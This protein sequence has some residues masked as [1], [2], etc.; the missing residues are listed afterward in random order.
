[1]GADRSQDQEAFDAADRA[2]KYDPSKSAYYVQRG[3]AR[4]SLGHGR[5]DLEVFQREDIDPAFQRGEPSAA[6]FGL[7]AHA[8]LAA[9]REKTGVAAVALI[10]D[11]TKD[12]DKAIKESSGGP[13]YT[14]LLDGGAAAY[15][16]LANLDTGSSIEQR[17]DCLKDAVRLAKLS[18]NVEYRPYPEYAWINLGNAEEDF[19]F[20]VGDKGDH[21]CNAIDAFGKAGETA[22]KAG[23]SPAF[24]HFS[25]GRCRCKLVEDLGA[26]L[27][28][29]EQAC[30]RSI[31]DHLQ[32][33][34]DELRK[35]IEVGMDDP[36]G[37]LTN[38]YQAEAN[39]WR[40]KLY[41]LKAAR[42]ADDKESLALANEAILAA[43]EGV[44]ETSENW[45]AYQDWSAK[46]A[47]KMG[48][49]ELAR[50]RAEKLLNV[51]S[52][53]LDK[54][55]R[56]VRYLVDSYT[57]QGDLKAGLEAY[58]KYLDAPEFRAAG[59]SRVDLL[60]LCSFHISRNAAALWKDN[61][62]LCEQR[63]R[64]A[65]KL[66]E[67]IPDPVGA[68][69]A[70][71]ALAEHMIQANLSDGKIADFK[72][73]AECLAKA[74]ALQPSLPASRDARIAL[75]EA[76]L[77]LAGLSKLPAAER[78]RYATKGFEALS[79]VAEAASN[80]AQRLRVAELRK[81]LEALSKASK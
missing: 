21:Y 15:V 74:I 71:L 2:V 58:K 25:Q 11:A 42:P 70:Y 34:L 12:Y 44:K 60:T 72:E 65:I 54:K 49:P 46:I 23:R 53:P 64:Q 77:Q 50:Q 41:F 52:A 6:A 39:Y 45:P 19:T 14:E 63:A 80:S 48:Q 13:Y 32:T 18:T 69:K 62:Q 3:F 38:N 68:S 30:G 5:P 33:A 35:A 10:N 31:D 51:P 8:Q 56:G 47:L 43:S 55:A 20:V 78:G 40:A 26:G 17:R 67:E 59:R 76:S 28:E 9:S 22:L 16:E 24:A 36:R 66:A 73:Y 75:A 79:G 81:K 1:V 37:A 4:W 29:P 7:R 57:Q 27:L 61:R